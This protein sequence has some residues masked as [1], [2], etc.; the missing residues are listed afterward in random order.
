V[1]APN[2]G[3]PLV[4]PLPRRGD[5]PAAAEAELRARELQLPVEGVGRADLRQ[6]FDEPRGP[7]L[8]EAIDILAPRG[9]RVRA[10]EDGTIVKLFF[11]E[12]G[13]RTVYQFDPDER[14]CY[15]YA[16][17][18]RYAEGLAEGQRVRR[19]DLVGY[20][21]TSGNAPPDT[22]HLHFAIFRLGPD[23][24]WWEGDPIDPYGLLR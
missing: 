20:V 23:K 17:L 7:R 9:A 18:D 22:P 24:R 5:H 10:V 11:S 3:I 12:R 6:T 2:E 13:G 14:Y 19:G 4:P 15:Y 16:H 1:P 8:H 21:G